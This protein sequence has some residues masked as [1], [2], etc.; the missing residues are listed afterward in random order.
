LII[1]HIKK[2]SLKVRK[3]KIIKLFALNHQ[4]K[5]VEFKNGKHYHQENKDDG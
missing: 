3:I 5:F 4:S 1:L 2:V